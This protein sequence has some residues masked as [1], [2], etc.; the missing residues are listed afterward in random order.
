MEYER[1]LFEE[2]FRGEKKS[3]VFRSQ[4]KMDIHM[5]RSK[6]LHFNLQ[7]IPRVKT[8]TC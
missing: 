2:H 6:F 4:D 1:N 5:N 3:P 7:D 8:N